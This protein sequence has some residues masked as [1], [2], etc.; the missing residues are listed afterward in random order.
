MTRAISH[1]EPFFVPAELRSQFD[2]LF[3]DLYDGGRWPSL[4]MIREDGQVIVR[5]EVPGM[6][7][8]EI[9]V[10]VEGG[11]LTIAGTHE[12]STEKEEAEY[13]HRER[14][15]GAFH[16]TLALPD[17]TDPKEIKA[18]VNDGVLE[19]LIPVQAEVAAEAVTITPTAKE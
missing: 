10:K 11:L 12:E 1:W 5:A 6:K 13:V 17:G 15:Y 19:I 4:D 18:T 14:R 9:E 8:D 16:R 2:R 7:P 3:T